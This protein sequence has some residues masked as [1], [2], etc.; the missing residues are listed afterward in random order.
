MK[1]FSIM[2]MRW[3]PDKA[4]LVLSSVYEL[5]SFGYFQRGSVKEVALFVSRE[6]VQRS[7]QGDRQ[8]VLHKEYVCHAQVTAQGL[9]VAIITDKEYPAR[10]AYSLLFK[11][12]DEF[13]RAQ[14]NWS[15]IQ[16][17]SDLQ[18]PALQQLLTKYQNPNDADPVS[19]IQKDLEDT[20]QII[21]KSID[22]LLASGEKLETLAEKSQDLSFQSKAF[23]KNSEKLNSCCVIL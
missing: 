10:V 5:G 17:D 23:L 16:N 14:T 2:V 9:A 13:M 18:V 12:L 1:L 4:P 3:F 19:R 22:D 15:N 8:S 11:C 7:K 6:V 20:K 21:L